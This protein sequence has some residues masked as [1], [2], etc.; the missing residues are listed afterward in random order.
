[1]PHRFVRNR[2]SMRVAR[3]DSPSSIH[4]A[5]LREFDHD[6]IHARRG[7]ISVRALDRWAI[8]SLVDEHLPNRDDRGGGDH[9][10]AADQQPHE[11]DAEDAEPMRC[12]WDVVDTVMQDGGAFCREE[13]TPT[14]N[15]PRPQMQLQRLRTG[16][17]FH[18]TG[19]NYR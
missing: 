10:D 16:C 18:T 11:G 14:S 17:L 19:R 1:M 8:E 12:C 2:D 3:P 6:P 5:A 4:R 15:I 13:L 7:S 9:A